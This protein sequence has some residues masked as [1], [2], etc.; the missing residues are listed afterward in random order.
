[1][2]RMSR[3]AAILMAAI[4]VFGN[5]SLMA[6]EINPVERSL[7]PDTGF[8]VT[9]K[10]VKYVKPNG[11]FLKDSWLI[12]GPQAW[13][14]DGDGIMA[15]GVRVVNGK[16]WTLT[17]EGAAAP[18]DAYKATLMQAGMRAT[19]APGAP[20][21]PTATPAIGA[22]T[23]PA[24]P[25]MAPANV[26]PATPGASTAPATPGAPATPA[27]APAASAP[28]AS[29]P[30]TTTPATAVSANTANAA[31]TNASAAPA[32]AA[33]SAPGGATPPTP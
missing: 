20:T 12:I 33:P 17:L 7:Y 30:A 1:M 23:A 27:S 4:L 2:K 5:G 9:Y 29:A 31:P 32:N 24:T 6:S 22:P 13:C 16:E 18:L 10:G 8:K 3:F 21:A 25:V 26:A 28:A 14:F 19:A 11:E 15:T